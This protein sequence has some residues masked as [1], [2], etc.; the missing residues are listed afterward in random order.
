M[1]KR[2][3]RDTS[4]NI[5]LVTGL[6]FG[7]LLTGVGVAVDYSG[8]TSE[9]ARL[10]TAL[11]AAVL[12]AA[13]EEDAKNKDVRKTVEKLVHENFVPHSSADAK[14]LEIKVKVDK[15][16]I[17]ASATMDYSTALMGIFGKPTLPLHVDSGGPR[18]QIPTVNV[19]LVVDTTDSMSGTNMADLQVAANELIDTFADSRADVKMSLVPY[20]QYVNVGVNRGQQGWVDTSNDRHFK[21]PSSHE[22]EAFS[23]G[24]A[25]TC[26]QTGV[27]IP[28]YA[29]VDGV[30]TQTGE[31]PETVC[32]GGTQGRS[33]GM[34]STYIPGNEKEREFTGCMGSR[35]A[36]LNIQAAAS[37]RDP[38]PAAMP[39][40]RERWINED[41]SKSDWREYTTDEHWNIRCGQEL[42]PLTDNLNRIRNRVNSLTT[43]GE[44]HLGAGLIWGWRTLD[45]A[46][47]FTQAEDGRDARSVMIFMT[48]GE[49]STFQRNHEHVKAGFNTHA[50]RTG[51][52]KAED[53]CSAAKGSDVE[54]YTVAYNLAG[55]ALSGETSAMLSR[56]ASSPG[57]A[58]TPSNRS[59][60]IRAFGDITAS[61]AQVRLD[62]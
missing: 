62:Y 9:Y 2:F 34:T 1:L 59:D 4:G 39:V 7:V 20:G 5:A 45:P 28:V 21:E 46:M 15:D 48:D 29:M 40:V 44:T 36:P 13:T 33:L 24:T 42:T 38:I 52:T 26:N 55:G 58:F 47:P 49:N 23:G 37:R 50:A 3:Q 60:L 43:E 17:R 41:G 61:L 51:L 19:A 57:H 25:P 6:T 35:D 32:T 10:Q 53:I 11:D 56:C 8:S 30:K 16:D 14:T 18:R 31:T 27:M 12:A 22:Y 54:I